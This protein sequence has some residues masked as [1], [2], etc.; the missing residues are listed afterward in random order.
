MQL[1][2]VLIASALV[3]AVCVEGL[4][5]GK[6]YVLKGSSDVNFLKLLSA[7]LTLF[8][9]Q[10]TNCYVLTMCNMLGTLFSLADALLLF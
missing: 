5:E 9:V 3:L 4:P 7:I 10:L 6:I 8:A 2:K 1:A